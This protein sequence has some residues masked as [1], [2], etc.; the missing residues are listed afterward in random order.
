MT[1]RGRFRERIDSNRTAST[2]TVDSFGSRN[3]S[4]NALRSSD[5]KNSIFK[6]AYG[7]RSDLVLVTYNAL[8]TYNEIRNKVKN[9]PTYHEIRTYEKSLR[10]VN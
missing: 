8:R 1:Y 5:E 4:H 2:Q 7:Y 10:G 3:E 9:Y 6:G